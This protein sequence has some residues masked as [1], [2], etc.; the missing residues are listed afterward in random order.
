[1]FQKLFRSL[2]I[3]LMFFSMQLF[4]VE[5]NVAQQAELELLKGIGPATARA[6]VTE[7]DANGPFSSP[8]EL[9]KR[10]RGI[11]PKSAQGLV[12]NGLVFSKPAVDKTTSPA[13]SKSAQSLATANQK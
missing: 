7:R 11:G 3:L 4:A 10:V 2:S 8:E 13:K 1:M 9:A 5:V 6:I 12:E